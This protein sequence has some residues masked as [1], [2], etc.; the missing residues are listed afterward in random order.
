MNSRHWT[1]LIV[2]DEQ[3][4]IDVSLMV[5][6][7]FEYMG[8][9]LR[10]L[11][12]NSATAARE[13]FQ[14]EG[15]IAAA[16]IDVVMETEHAGLDLVEYVRNELNNHDT[17]I[18]L[19]T[20]NPGA[21]PP[22]D[23]IRHMEVDDYKEKTELTAERL[24]ISLLTALRAYRS[25]RASISKSR[26]VANMSHEIRT[27]LNA[28]IGLSNLV[29]RT[30]LTPRQRDHL[31]KIES[32]GKHLLGVI[33][34]IL[35][36]SKIEAGKLKLEQIDFDLEV[37]LNNVMSMVVQR[38]QEKGL[39]LV[40]DVPCDQSRKLCGDVQRLTQ[41]LLNYVNNAIK[42][43]ESGEIQ[44]RATTA[45]SPNGQRQMLRFEVSDT[46][47]GL[48]P[49]EAS[50]LF[51]EFEQAD[52]STTRNYGGTG[53]GL[54]IAKNLATL[55]GGEVG[56]SSK[57]GVGSVFWFT[58]ELEASRGGERRNLVPDEHY[59]G[60]RVLVADDNNATRQL[61]VRK[62]QNMRFKVDAVAD[63]TLAVQAARRALEDHHPYRLIFLDWRMPEMDGI[64]AAREIRAFDEGEHEH[65]HIVCI[66]GAGHDEF[67]AQVHQNDFDV[68]L[69]KPVTTEQL[70]DA[71]VEALGKSQLVKP[72]NKH[73]LELD[74]TDTGSTQT[75]AWQGK[76]A[77]YSVLLVDD[78]RL[79]RQIGAELLRA[80]GIETVS[81][82]NG[83]DALERL[84]Q[85]RFDL[86]L[87]DIHM[88]VMDG[89]TTVRAL[90][91]QG[92][93][94]NLP[95][96]A[97]TAGVLTE[98]DTSWVESGFNDLLSKPIVPEML[99]ATLER[100]LP[101]RGPA[102][103]NVPHTSTEPHADHAYWLK[104]LETLLECGDADAQY[105]LS[106]HADIFREALGR[107]F[108]AIQRAIDS[109]EFEKA[110]ELVHQDRSQS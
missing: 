30:E 101:P 68:M 15:D 17:R 59:W 23:I 40:L 65:Q 61:L 75:L 90:R 24:E 62:L 42:F 82:V 81:A 31:G 69:I 25:I 71:V 102:A 58:A 22:L 107:R 2:D 64:T 48:T 78:D 3:D 43:T 51:Q 106:E 103:A 14:S 54:A 98:R 70:F 50:R 108:S 63:G 1:I 18:V 49:A 80:A 53:L 12:A 41:V 28:I 86:V 100:W 55:M 45:G 26:F 9:G 44:I 104:K 16:Y 7:D 36:F 105:V 34:D 95:V 57:K 47:I 46:G 74:A 19:R 8:K 76:L 96:L 33:N 56:V 109:F 93:M 39:E 97:M 85:Q 91:A 10:V 79:Y 83:A 92:T 88:P 37:L 72:S 5:F 99:Y 77:G 87:L 66:T 13:I 84:A 32:A 29:L 20:G 35:D 21:A 38:A 110:L 73:S 60:E 27:P 4:V 6:E 67:D 11:T 52:T 94:S 89:Y